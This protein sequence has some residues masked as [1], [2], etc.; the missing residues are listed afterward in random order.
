MNG[1]QYILL[2]CLLHMHFKLFYTDI[3]EN[4]AG[5]LCVLCVNNM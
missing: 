5:Q 4:I 1:F 2:W 3:E